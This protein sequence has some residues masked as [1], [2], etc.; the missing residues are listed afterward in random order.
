MESLIYE[1][2]MSHYDIYTIYRNFQGLLM[3]VDDSFF[4]CLALPSPDLSL[5]C[6]PLASS[7]WEADLLARWLRDGLSV[8]FC[9]RW[10]M[11]IQLRHNNVTLS[12]HHRVGHR[13]WPCPKIFVDLHG[14]QILLTDDV[15][16]GVCRIFLRY[17]FFFQGR[18]FTLTPTYRMPVHDE[19]TLHI[20]R[21]IIQMSLFPWQKKTHLILRM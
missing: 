5:A 2:S 16:L 4:W 15:Q 19:K 10:L 1:V 21:S 13:F 17:V 14:S 20:S 3:T 8:C 12:F 9:F 7:P 6:A 11:I 18:P